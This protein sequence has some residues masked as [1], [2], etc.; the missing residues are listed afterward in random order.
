LLGRAS[1]SNGDPESAHLLAWGLLQLGH[2][3]S[4][5]AV[6][7]RYVSIRPDARTGVLRSER[8][9]A[10]RDH[11]RLERLIGAAGSAPQP[12]STLRLPQ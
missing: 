2:A 6:L 5:A 1:G 7:E 12:S 11:P 3:D 4:A 9:R 10:L 8:F